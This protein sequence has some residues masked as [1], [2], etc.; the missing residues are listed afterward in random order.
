[1]YFEAIVKDRQV[2]QTN[3]TKETWKI[4]FSQVKSKQFLKGECTVMGS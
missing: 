3:T 1:M 4:R 2:L